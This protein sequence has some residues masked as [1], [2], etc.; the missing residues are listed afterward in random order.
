MDIFVRNVPYQAS[1]KNLETF[2]QE[3]FRP[4]SIDVFSCQ[5]L[6]SQGCAILTVL[7]TEK[8]LLFLEIYESASREGTLRTGAQT[9]KYM[10]RELLCSPS[11]SKSDEMLLR[12]LRKRSKDKEKEVCTTAE[13]VERVF[14]YTGVQCGFW[15]YQASDLV[16]VSQIMYQRKGSIMFG[17]KNLALVA[18]S[19]GVAHE[20]YRLDISYSSVQ[21]I[22]TGS[23]QDPSLTITLSRAPR[24][25]QQST[26]DPNSIQSMLDALGFQ[27]RAQAKPKRRRVPNLDGPYDDIVSS[28]F[29]YRVLIRDPSKINPIG[30]LL[31]N[32]WEMPPSIPWPTSVVAPRSMCGTEMHLLIS[33]LCNR[34]KSFTFGLQFQVQ[35]LAQNGYLT[36]TRVLELLPHILQIFHRSGGFTTAESVRKLS[37]QLPYAGPEVDGKIFATEHL[38]ELIRKNEMAITHELSHNF[39]FTKQHLHIGLVHKATV[40]PAGV[41]LEGPEPETKNRVLRAYSDHADHFIRVNFSDEDGEQ[42]H[43]DRFVSFE[44]VF[45]LQVQKHT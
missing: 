8:A 39:K 26:S 44:D 40:T 42:I 16:F 41:Y 5:K 14:E 17:K 32:G 34:Y 9:L 45:P 36:P 18:H 24:V 7:D 6:K 37:R 35:R 31:R 33:T 30:L 3:R 19:D 38:R 1:N 21:S 12:H 13:Q 11:R 25:Y 2:F 29:V 27:P 4:F 10:G 28:C 43:F 20:T 15:D 22:T 23:F